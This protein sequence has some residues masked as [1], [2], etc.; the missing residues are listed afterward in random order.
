MNNGWLI[1]SLWVYSK[2]VHLCADMVRLWKKNLGDE[3]SSING[4]CLCIDQ[5]KKNLGDE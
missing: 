4:V 2:F 1:N 3:W 5:W